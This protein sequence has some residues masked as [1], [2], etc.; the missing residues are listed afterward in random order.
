MHSWENLKG[1]PHTFMKLGLPHNFH[2]TWMLTPCMFQTQFGQIQ[3]LK[4]Q[5]FLAGLF[6]RYTSHM[7][8]SISYHR[9]K[10]VMTGLSD[11][12]FIPSMVVSQGVAKLTGRAWD[13]LALFVVNIFVQSQRK[14][15]PKENWIRNENTH[16]RNCG[17]KTEIVEHKQYKNKNSKNTN[18]IS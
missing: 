13:T 1:S 11:S 6:L 17:I 15:T 5:D 2:W 3:I 10:G 8:G 18:Q 7:E 14:Q 9:W 4:G 12:M 16:I